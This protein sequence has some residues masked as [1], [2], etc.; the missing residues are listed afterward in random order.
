MGVAFIHPTANVEAGVVLGEDTRVWAWSH[1]CQGAVIGDHCIIGEGVYIGP[2][3]HIGHR[4][5]IQNHSL[6]YEGVEIADEVFIGPNVVTTNDEFPRAL[7]E[8]RQRFR[9]TH[10]GRG[11]T[12]CANS[13]I[14]CGHT[15]GEHAFVGAGSVVT[16]DIK[17]GWIAFGNPAHHIRPVHPQPLKQPL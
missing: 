11:A 8:W 16:Q 10:I 15:I 14:V 3:V 1:V 12:V 17:P 13:T 2:H 4:C 9:A 5:K 6:I 7:G